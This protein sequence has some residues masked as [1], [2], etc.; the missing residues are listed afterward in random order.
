[1]L[2]F[3]STAW[4]NKIKMNEKANEFEVYLEILLL[5]LPQHCRL[6]PARPHLPD[7]RVHAVA[8]HQVLHEERLLRMR[9]LLKDDGH[10]GPVGVAEQVLEC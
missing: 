4:K 7:E 3:R 6:S 5:E 2:T 8:E 9:V 10:L 1:M